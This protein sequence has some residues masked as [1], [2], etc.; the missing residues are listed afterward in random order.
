[1]MDVDLDLD[2]RTSPESV[3]RS[4]GSDRANTT[5]NAVASTAPNPGG[6]TPHSANT[7]SGSASR[8]SHSTPGSGAYNCLACYQRKTKCD[9][10]LD[11]CSN[12]SKAGVTCTYPPQRNAAPQKRGPY[13]K[14]VVKKNEELEQKILALEATVQDLNKKMQDRS[15]ELSV[16][17]QGTSISTNRPGQGIPTPVEDVIFANDLPPS[18]SGSRDNGSGDFSTRASSSTSLA[19]EMTLPSVS[20]FDFVNKVRTFLPHMESVYKLT[21]ASLTTDLGMLRVIMTFA[22]MTLQVVLATTTD[23]GWL[24]TRLVVPNSILTLRQSTNI[25]PSSRRGSTLFLKSYTFPHLKSTSLGA[26]PFQMIQLLAW[27]L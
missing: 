8:R 26:R 23:S 27:T 15:R 12:C 22:E 17:L 16:E 2:R 20:W 19:G 6:K 7:A 1:M 25:G 14:A 11:G 21:S 9:R 18:K 24:L 3:D 4:E 13:N 5:I 10:R